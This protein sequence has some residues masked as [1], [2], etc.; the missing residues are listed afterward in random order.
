SCVSPL[1]RRAGL[2]A[3][4]GER[5]RVR[6]PR[7]TLAP[8]LDRRHRFSVARQPDKPLSGLDIPCAHA[9]DLFA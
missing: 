4:H 8:A 1:A 3:R 9:Q 2:H 6:R 5:A 7:S